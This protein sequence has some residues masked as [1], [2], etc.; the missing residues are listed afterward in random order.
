MILFS[1][2]LLIV[3]PVVAH[4]LE[5]RLGLM[6]GFDV[7]AMVFTVSCAR[8]LQLSHCAIIQAH[9]QADEENRWVLLGIS[10]VVSLVILA[11][12][13]SELMNGTMPPVEKFPFIIATIILAWLF[14]NTVFTLHYAHMHYGTG[15]GCDDQGLVF[16]G[17]AEPNYWDFFYFAVAIGVAFATSDVNVE[18]PLMRRAVI[19][20]SV[21]AF[22]FNIGVVGFTINL[23]AGMHG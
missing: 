11:A 16:P 15:R 13:A 19:A 12:V 7:A 3:S 21:I 18:S 9:A 14:G 8:L 17:T 23:L 4:W 2:I 10:I 1:L 5:W 6:I 22:V 20:H